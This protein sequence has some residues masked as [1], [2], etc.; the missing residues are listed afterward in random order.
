[1]RRHQ[2]LALA[3]DLHAHDALVPALDDP[4]GADHALEGFAT[5]VRRVEFGPVL[6]PATVLGGDQCAFYGGFS[7]TH[8]KIDYLKLVIH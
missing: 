7:V 8:L 4:P 2:Q 1:M 3:A 6:Q 5:T